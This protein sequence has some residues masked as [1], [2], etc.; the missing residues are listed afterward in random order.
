MIRIGRDFTMTALRITL[1]LVLLERS[2]VMVSARLSAES[3]AHSS[4]PGHFLLALGLAEIVAAV[5]FLV[6]RTVAI[7][8][9][10]LLVV[11]LFAAAFHILHREYDIGALA[12]WTAAVLAVLAHRRSP[13][14]QTA[15]P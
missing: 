8:A 3:S 7:G 11:F 13:Q 2:C 12:I 6:P 1:G 5:L 14:I 10:A 4:G 15:G 9:Y